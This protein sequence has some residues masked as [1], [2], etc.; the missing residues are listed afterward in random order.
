MAALPAAAMLHAQSGNLYELPDYEYFPDQQAKPAPTPTPTP[1]AMPA[2]TPTPASAILAA[3]ASPS[4][5][6][7]GTAAAGSSSPSSTAAAAAAGG[8]AAARADAKSL[9]TAQ[10]QSAAQI[11]STA[12]LAA[13]VPGYTSAPLP[14]QAYSDDVDGLEAA[15]AA[16]AGS[17]ESWRT[18]ANPLRPT[19]TLGADELTRTKAIEDDPQAYTQGESLGG[20][21]GSCT[22]VPPATT[23]QGFYE[24][25]CN[26][27]ANLQ[28]E[29]RSCSIPLVAT[30][31]ESA[32][33]R[34]YAE[35]PFHTGL[36]PPINSFSAALA[37]GTCTNIG[38]ANTCE[39]VRA[40]GG[41]PNAS[42]VFRRTDILQCST[43]V[44][45]LA[46][47]PVPATGQLWFAR[48]VTRT[49][50]TARDESSCAA[51]SGNTSCSAPVETCTSSDPVT[52]IVDGVE[53]TAPCWAW[54]RSY[55]CSTVTQASDCSQLEGNASCTFA[56]ETCLD[57]PP[58]GA[59]QV[60]ERTYH[61]PIPGNQAAGGPEYICGGELYCINGECEP[62]VREASTELKDA[63]VG[64][65]A[66]GQANAEFDETTLT[67][68]S[69]ER[70]TCH[71]PVFGLIDCCAGKSSGLIT[72]AAGAA[73]LV[74]GPVAIAA[75]AT[76]FLTL[77]ACSAEEKQLDVKDRMGLCHRV[78]SYCS[79]S[80]LG[81]CKTRRTAYCCFESKLTRILQ[82]QGR[83]Q[84]G[85]PWGSPKRE[86][87]TGFSVE[88]FARLDL[89]LMDFTEVYAEFVDAVKLPDEIETAQ[90]I[91]TRIEA[92]Y[93]ERG[94]RQ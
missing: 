10:R 31:Q 73:A 33:Y 77:F 5:A 91:Q 64:L 44:S 49:A 80:V 29:Q 35:N 68:F 48:D 89:S 32:V 21:A 24:A 63:L 69:G 43:P 2:P 82:E 55:Q 70:E 4:A 56:S 83:P 62:I 39:V 3:S 92:Y 76:P 17:N 79:S 30:V 67:L 61:C 54:S 1:S 8:M 88:Q 36:A 13:T 23:G 14:Q 16:A 38:R 74:G 9:A 60:R 93:R 11:P 6:A 28:Q 34:Y 12:D 84:L 59:C 52:R 46:G 57:D 90:Q 41:T 27:G 53:V 42:C 51:L 86:Q 18:V 65:H 19:V 81:I 87:C 45:G 47:L 71:K 7:A 72:T 78:G 94:S 66:L 75:L 25:T 22:P 26:V 20:A 85:I 50:T 15:G 58:N 37:N 40:Y